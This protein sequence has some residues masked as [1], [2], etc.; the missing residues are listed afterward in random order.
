[1]SPDLL[2]LWYAA[3]QSP[4]GFGIKTVDRVLLRQQL[5]AARRGHEQ[6]SNYTIIF[7]QDETE[8]FIVRSSDG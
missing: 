5:Y 2:S 3:V 8:L 4:H 7:P 6:F 1:M